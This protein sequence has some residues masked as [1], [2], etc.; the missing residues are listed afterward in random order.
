MLSTEE[1]RSKQPPT[2]PQPTVERKAHGWGKRM[3]G[4]GWGGG[5]INTIWWRRGFHVL[6]TIKLMGTDWGRREKRSH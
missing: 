4:Q 5:I 3:L 2:S 6:D 1:V